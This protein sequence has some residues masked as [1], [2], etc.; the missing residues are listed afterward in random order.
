MVVNNARAEVKIVELE[1]TIEVFL[2]QLEQGTLTER[3]RFS[4]VDL[5]IKEAC[6]FI[7][8]KNILS[9]KMS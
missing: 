4:T 7:K 2:Q 3:E 5:L 6:L 1:T 9:I 8:V